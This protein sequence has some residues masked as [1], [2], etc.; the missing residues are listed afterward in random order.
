MACSARIRAVTSGAGSAS[1]TAPVPLSAAAAARER[2]IARESSA[3]GTG[4]L[5]RLP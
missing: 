1:G 2:S 4:G 5:N 3:A